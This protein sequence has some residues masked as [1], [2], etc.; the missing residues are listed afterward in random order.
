[1]PVQAFLTPGFAHWTTWLA[2]GVG[3]TVTGLVFG[4]L[5][6]VRRRRRLATFPADEDLPW[7][8]LLDLLR[9]R[10]HELA[11]AGPPPCEDLPPD[12]L[13]ELLLS[14]VPGHLVRCP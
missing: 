7:E 12:E 14:R 10:S 8:E 11:A 6:R 9:A 3:V 5:R 1:M 2:V 13:L 4:G